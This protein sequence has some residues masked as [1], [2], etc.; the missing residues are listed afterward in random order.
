M[1]KKI[2][3]QKNEMKSRENGAKNNLFGDQFCKSKKGQSYD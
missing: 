3:D 2:V 1:M